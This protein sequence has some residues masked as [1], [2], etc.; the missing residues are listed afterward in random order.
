MISAKRVQNLWFDGAILLL[1]NVYFIKFYST[2]YGYDFE[3]SNEKN[4]TDI[5]KIQADI[6]SRKCEGSFKY[7]PKFSAPTEKFFMKKKSFDDRSVKFGSISDKQ[8]N[9]MV[10]NFYGSNDINKIY[11]A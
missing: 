9:K 8:I 10:N 2:I 6:S 1:A 5:I 11:S 4:V 3:M 7:S